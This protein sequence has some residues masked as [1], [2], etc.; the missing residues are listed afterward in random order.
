MR[1]FS[2][3]GFSGGDPIIDEEVGTVT[4]VTKK[5]YAENLRLGEDKDIHMM[6]ARIDSEKFDMLK[7]FSFE[8]ENP[9]HEGWMR[10]FS[11]Y[12]GKRE[13]SAGFPLGN[14]KGYDVSQE[15]ADKPLC[16]YWRV[17]WP[18]TEAVVE[19]LK[20][21]SEEIS[22]NFLGKPKAKGRTTR[23]NDI[24]TV[25][26]IMK[27][28]ASPFTEEDVARESSRYGAPLEQKEIVEGLSKKYG[29]V[30]DFRF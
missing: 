20:R 18:P 19:Y 26:T 27:R 4:D 28:K 1:A 21:Q 23:S 22:G 15:M 14:V 3:R 24:L 29:L 6:F 5:K 25:S 11:V 30:C 12:K 10:C 9:N 7:Q 13:A 16:N 2:V 8:S 17:G